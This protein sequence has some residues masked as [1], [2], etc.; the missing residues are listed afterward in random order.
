[1]AGRAAQGPGTSDL[2]A[3]VNTWRYFIWDSNLGLPVIKI[4]ETPSTINPGSPLLDPESPVESSPP[5]QNASDC[6]GYNHVYRF[7]N[8]KKRSNPSESH[9]KDG[10]WKTGQ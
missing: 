6:C 1:M 3:P 4:H 7:S 2:Q 10:G 5:A 9:F 8:R